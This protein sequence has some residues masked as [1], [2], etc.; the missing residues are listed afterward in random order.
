M[1][2]S[3]V[4]AQSSLYVQALCPDSELFTSEL[5]RWVHL[6]QR[7]AFAG[8]EVQVPLEWKMQKRELDK[9]GKLDL[10]LFFCL[11]DTES[12]LRF[13]FS[14]AFSSLALA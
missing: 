3:L 9:I 13:V 11:V 5:K 1:D 7:P 12:A 2:P 14:N 4:I 6:T 10:L 8:R